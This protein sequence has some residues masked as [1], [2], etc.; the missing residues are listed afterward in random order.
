MSKDK[1]NS[2]SDIKQMSTLLLSGATMLA[3][4]CPDCKVP[5]FK[6]SEKIFCPKCGRKAVYVS[7]D[8]EAKQIEHAHSFSETREMVQDILTGKLNF[9]AQK[10]ADCEKIE[11]M[12][13]ILQ[14][15]DMLIEIS[16]KIASIQRN[17]WNKK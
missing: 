4:S 16:I 17:S 2:S 10:L 8:D 14:I 15:I 9:M 6:K 3:D 11:E 12:K 13:N 7:S 5:L 1:E